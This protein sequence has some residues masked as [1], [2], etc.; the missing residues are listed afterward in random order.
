M[1]PDLERLRQSLE[2][3]ST[4]VDYLGVPSGFG[5]FR[6]IAAVQNK[7]NQMLIARTC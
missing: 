2:R 1:T 7:W 5:L 6:T 3:I 4:I